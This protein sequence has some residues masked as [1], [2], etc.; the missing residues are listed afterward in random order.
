MA[1]Q[2]RREIGVHHRRVAARDELHQRRDLVADRHLLEARAPRDLFRRGLVGGVAVAVHQADGDGAE[3][4]AIG[5]R[6]VRLQLRLVE[7][8]HDLAMRTQALVRLHDF[9]IEDF[10]QPDMQVEE[11]RAVLVA[12]PELVGEAPSSPPAGCARPCAPAARWSR[13]WCPSAPPRRAPPGSAHRLP[14]PECRECP[15]ARRRH[16][17]PALRRAACGSHSRRP[18]PAPRYR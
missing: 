4:L 11:A 12:D 16:N 1:A 5:P 3:A 13:R 9:G 15:G 10:R 7:R 8:L 17:A 6:Q 14:R 2:D 18:A